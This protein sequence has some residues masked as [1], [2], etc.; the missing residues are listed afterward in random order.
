[1]TQDFR[2]FLFPDIY[3]AHFHSFSPGTL[4]T[5]EEAEDLPCLYH[6]TLA[7]VPTL[8]TLSGA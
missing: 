1:M 4:W 8:T 6:H 7:A 3:K 2:F 5:D